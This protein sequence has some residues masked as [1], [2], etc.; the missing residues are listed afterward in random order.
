MKKGKIFA[1]TLAMLTALCLGFAGCAEEEAPAPPPPPETT[2]TLVIT[3]N[4]THNQ[5]VIT[6]ITIYEG[7]KTTPVKEDS[8]SVKFGESKS[9]VLAAG[10]YSITVKDNSNYT[11][12]GSASVTIGGTTNLSWNGSSLQ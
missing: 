11:T 10:G 9:Y 12:T 5:D 7:G 4:T 3:N 1:V 8:V 2:G 6:K